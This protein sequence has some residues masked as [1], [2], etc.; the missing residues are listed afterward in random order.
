M[1]QKLPTPAPTRGAAAVAWHT[2]AA[3]G[4]QHTYI[5]I[6]NQKKTTRI[7]FG[8][9]EERH[10]PP[11]TTPKRKALPAARA[12]EGAALQA[13]GMKDYCRHHHY[14]LPTSTRYTSEDLNL[15]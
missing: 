11:G 5:N 12:A 7:I 3:R 1:G 15:N 14:H 4:A 2:A 13:E 8:S 6:T 10:A 9:C